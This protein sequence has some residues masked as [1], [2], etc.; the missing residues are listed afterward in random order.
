MPTPILAR[1]AL[2]PPPRQLCPGVRLAAVSIGAWLALE[3]LGAPLPPAMELSPLDA[4]RIAYF[5][6]G[7]WRERLNEW[8]ADEAAFDCAALTW[9]NVIADTAAFPK[10]LWEFLVAQW[11]TAAQLQPS[12]EMRDREIVVKSSSDGLGDLLRIAAAKFEEGHPVDA[13]LDMP[14]LTALA[15]WTARQIRSGAEWAQPSYEDL[16]RPELKQ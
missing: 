14:I 5:L 1:E 15:F 7:N 8:R 16:D 9:S 4:V 6:S 3:E 12:R 11:R 2:L 13:I 10:L